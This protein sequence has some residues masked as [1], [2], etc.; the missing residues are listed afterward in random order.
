MDQFIALKR[1]L[2][3]VCPNLEL[4][5]NEP[6][7]CHTMF[8]IGGPVP[9]MAC[10]KTIQEAQYAL[11]TADSFEIEPFFL[12]KGS[13]LLVSD[14]GANVF[15]IKSVGGLEEL[16][17]EGEEILYAGSGV[18]LARAAEFAADRSLAGM[19]FAHGIPG[20]LGGAVFMNAGAYGGDMAQIVAFVDCITRTG[21]RQRVQG[22]QLAFGY[23]RS[24]FSDETR[25]ILGAGLR[26]HPGSREEIRSR[27]TEL[28]R[29]RREKQPLEYP[30]AGSTFKRPA[31]YFAG[32]LIEQCGLKGRQVG[33]A[34]VS[35]KHAGF[36]INIGGA[37]C[38][39]VLRLIETVRE[40][41]FRQTGVI[42]EPEIRTLGI[43]FADN[44]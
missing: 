36:I 14:A 2:N 5:E 27:M 30:S 37:T 15:V 1:E 8:R 10:P 40:T 31:G 20:S 39:D 32:T 28:M 21:E 29:Q 44:R 35:E 19:E 7:S 6:L 11:K 43:S 16:H 33:G 25:L 18:S 24:V 42:L 41:V 34:Q 38:E 3:T 4:R 22:S 9:L 13:N 26:L 12:G 17:L 23:R